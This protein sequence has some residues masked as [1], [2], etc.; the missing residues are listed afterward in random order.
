MFK[1]LWLNRRK[2][3][4]KWSLTRR[5][6]KDGACWYW[7]RASSLNKPRS[8]DHLWCC[9]KCCSLICWKWRPWSD[10]EAWCTFLSHNFNYI[11]ETR[12]NVDALHL[13]YIFGNFIRKIC[14]CL[15]FMAIYHIAVTQK[16]D[17]CDLLHRWPRTKVMQKALKKAFCITF[18]LHL[19]ITCH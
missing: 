11:V 17:I 6:V 9:T 8:Y 15:F 3:V 18:V 14:S 16:R 13:D 12:H 2:H 19:V 10:A 7:S 4:V 1:T 5:H